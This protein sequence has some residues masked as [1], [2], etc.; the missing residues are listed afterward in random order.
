[1]Q[2]G[3]RLSKGRLLQ[4]RRMRQEAGQLRLRFV[5]GRGKSGLHDIRV[6]GNARP[7]SAAFRSRE[8]EGKC[9]REYTA[10]GP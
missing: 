6:A 9:H 5:L 1:M 7:A 8:A 3:R 4:Y 10:D 2:G